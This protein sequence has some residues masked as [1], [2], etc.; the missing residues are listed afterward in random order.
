MNFPDLVRNVMQRDRGVKNT[1]AQANELIS[2]TLS[3]LK[4]TIKSRP[5][6]GTLDVIRLIFRAK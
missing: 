4:N 2:L 1:Y 3:E 5:I 6:R